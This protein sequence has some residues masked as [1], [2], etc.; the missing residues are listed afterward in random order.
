MFG[1]SRLDKSANRDAAHS[2]NKIAIL[3]SNSAF[4]GIL[5]NGG[6]ILF[7]ILAIFSV[8][9]NEMS[10]SFPILANLR[11]LGNENGIL[12]PIFAIF[13]V[14]TRHIIFIYSSRRGRHSGQN[15]RCTG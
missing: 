11:L 3:S 13:N 15:D 2:W 7:P 4:L 5:G 12:F 10:F 14:F 1:W 8:L 6:G 9:G